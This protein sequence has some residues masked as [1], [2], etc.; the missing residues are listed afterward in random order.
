MSGR[1]RAA[2][3]RAGLDVVQAAVTF[4]YTC[5]SHRGRTT[6]RKFSISTKV[7]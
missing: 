2:R 6:R 5:H 7:S 3:F 1:L 4:I